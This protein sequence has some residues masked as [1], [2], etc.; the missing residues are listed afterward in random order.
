MFGSSVDEVLDD[1]VLCVDGGAWGGG[2]VVVVAVLV[3]DVV[4]VVDA[5]QFVNVPLS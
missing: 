4:A 2:S 1:A 5:V 3:E